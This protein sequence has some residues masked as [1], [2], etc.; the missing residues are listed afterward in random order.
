MDFSN[1]EG[2]LK[3]RLL[4]AVRLVAC[5]S[6]VQLLS[7]C[8]RGSSNL[9]SKPLFAQESP[10]PKIDY[11][12]YVLVLS[13]DP[14]GQVMSGADCEIRVFVK[15]TGGS[16]T[17]GPVVGDLGMSAGDGY[18]YVNASGL[19]RGTFVADKQVVKNDGSEFVANYQFHVSAG[20]G[21]DMSFTLNTSDPFANSWQSTFVIHV[22]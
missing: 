4:N 1:L 8:D 9:L 5:M 7:G 12:R 20:P 10:Q 3:T 15:N 22:F 11:S 6:I 21:T 2:V 18:V 19:P 17:F 14:S 16:A 13:S